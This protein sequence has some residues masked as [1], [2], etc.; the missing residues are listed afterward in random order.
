MKS[1]QGYLPS[2]TARAVGAK[3]IEVTMAEAEKLISGIQ[4][5]F[6][7]RAPVILKTGSVMKGRGKV[8]TGLSKNLMAMIEGKRK[9]TKQKKY[10]LPKEKAFKMPSFKMPQVKGFK[11]W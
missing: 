6:E 4:T 10:I 2:F 5:G 9:M 11:A 1:E 7:F 8:K 3:P